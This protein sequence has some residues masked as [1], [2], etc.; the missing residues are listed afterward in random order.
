[1]EDK[2]KIAPA[3]L[4][5]SLIAFGT[6]GYAGAAGSSCESLLKLPL[7]S[8]TVTLAEVVPPGG[9]RAPGG[10]ANVQNTARF[11]Q[12]PAFCRVAATLKPSADSDIKIEVWLPAFGWNGKFEAVGNGGWA[13]TISYPA[14]AQALARGYAT[15]STDTGHSTPG[16]S[17]ALGHPDTYKFSGTGSGAIG[18]TSFTDAL[19][20]FTGTADTAN[21]VPFVF[22]GATFYAIGLDSLTVNIAGI[23]TAT[24][25]DPTEIFDIPL[26]IDDPDGEIPPVPVVILGRRATRRIW[27]RSPAWPPPAATGSP[28]TTSP[29]RLGR[30]VTLAAWDSSRTAAHRVTTPASAHHWVL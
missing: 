20:V 7:E 26:A 29:R 27:I 19:V 10:D 23:G 5:A 8:A 18:G 6:A 1:L 3:A 16:G 11:A 4:F 30:S 25:T 21:V 24:I 14:M 22:F 9:F 15:T 13:G 28:V 12:L 2:V 17:F